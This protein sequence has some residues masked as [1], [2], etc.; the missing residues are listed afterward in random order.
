MSKTLFVHLSSYP[1]DHVYLEITL[2]WTFLHL[3][4]FVWV[5]NPFF[6]GGGS[7]PPPPFLWNK[8]PWRVAACRNV[9]RIYASWVF[10]DLSHERPAGLDQCTVAFQRWRD[11][12][13]NRWK[14]PTIWR[15]KLPIKSGGFPMFSIA[16]LVYWRGLWWTNMTKLM[17]WLSKRDPRIKGAVVFLRISPMWDCDV[18]IY[19]ISIYYIIYNILFLFC[20]IYIYVL[21]IFTYMLSN[22][23]EVYSLKQQPMP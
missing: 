3:N 16:L 18:Y 15:C 13:T 7:T 20:Y 19:I 9:W 6:C 14:I 8:R 21:L 12:C 10:V 2:S 4:V 5:S 23:K 17:R 1:A 11:Q 22:D